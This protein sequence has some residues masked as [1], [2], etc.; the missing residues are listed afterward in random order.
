MVLIKTTTNIIQR[1][2]Q[3]E[4]G[5][6]VIIWQMFLIRVR[7]GHF[8]LNALMRLNISLYTRGD[9]QSVPHP[10]SVTEGRRPTSVSDSA[11]SYIVN[12]RSHDT[13]NSFSWARGPRRFNSRK[14][15]SRQGVSIHS[16]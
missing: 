5:V 1:F 4:F 2:F 10:L 6:A 16:R 11:D 7:A 3:R 12:N 14:G 8:M 9:E 13:Q 15:T